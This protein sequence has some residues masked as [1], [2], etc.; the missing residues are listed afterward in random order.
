MSLPAAG[1]MVLL[2][3]GCKVTTRPA[4]G[5]GAASWGEL[6]D[7]KRELFSGSATSVLTAAA[8]FHHLGFLGFL[9]IFTTVLAPLFGRAITRWVRAFAGFIVCHRS[10]LLKVWVGSRNLFSSRGLVVML[11]AVARVVKC[12]DRRILRV[13]MG[14]TPMSLL[15]SASLKA[16][17]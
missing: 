8:D 15:T 10:D 5:P 14:G 17:A 4:R 2:Q 16:N 13:I 3:F 1:A 9:A 11:G 12:G 7:P 6:N